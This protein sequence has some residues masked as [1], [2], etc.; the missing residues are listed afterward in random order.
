M[1]EKRITF[2]RRYK[3]GLSSLGKK[4]LLAGEGSG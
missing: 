1:Q 4:L 3:A 2:A